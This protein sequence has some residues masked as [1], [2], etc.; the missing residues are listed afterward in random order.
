MSGNLADYDFELPK[1]LIAQRPVVG[2]D[3]S[4]LLLL[5]R[6]T[7]AISDRRMSELPELL[8]RGD[9]LVVNDTRVEPARFLGTKEGSERPAEVLVHG[10]QREDGSRLALVRPSK[11]F[12]VGEVFVSPGGLRIE[13]GER[14]AGGSRIVRLLGPE[15]WATAMAEAG[16][17]PLPPYIERAADERDLEEYQTLFAR[18]AGAAAAPTAGLHFSSGL[19]ERLDERGVG[20]AALTLHVGI[21]TFQPVRSENLDEHEMHAERFRLSEGTRRLIDERRAAGGRAVAVGTTSLRALET[22]SADEWDSPGDI[23]AETRLFVRPPFRFRRV[24]ALLT[25]FHLPRSTL[26][27]LVAAFAGRENMLA[28]YAHA[29]SSDYRFY[30]YGDAMLILQGE[31][32]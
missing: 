22:P 15:S 24:D 6:D 3:G 10:E 5:S 21:G 23:G 29:V 28:A 18:E 2:R 17:M 32:P 9:L 26:L 16:H 1:S 4:R 12:G 13:I 20:T 30:S 8:A 7:G 11:R 27:M 31:L 19:L 25:N 14:T